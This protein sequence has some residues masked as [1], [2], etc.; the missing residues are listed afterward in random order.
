MPLFGSEKSLRKG[1]EISSKKV[2]GEE[3]E[4]QRQKKKTERK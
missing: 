2:K 3:I 1:E 4:D